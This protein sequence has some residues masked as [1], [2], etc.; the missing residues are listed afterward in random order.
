MCIAG[1]T[2]IDAAY[3][4][5]SSPDLELNAGKQTVEEC[6][7]QVVKML[8]N[9]VCH[10]NSLSSSTSSSSLLSSPSLLSLASSTT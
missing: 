8:V 4:A 9:K 6:I 5:P 2:G 3:E 10:A 7:Q 1:F